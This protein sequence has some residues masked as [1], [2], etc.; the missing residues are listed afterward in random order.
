MH[1]YRL[2]RYPAFH[3]SFPL[4]VCVLYSSFLCIKIIFSPFPSYRLSLSLC[5]NRSSLCQA[6]V[7]IAAKQDASSSL[8]NTLASSLLS[9]FSP[10]DVTSVTGRAVCSK[11]LQIVSSLSSRGYLAGSAQLLA[12]LVSVFTVQGTSATYGTYTG[13]VNNVSRAASS[14]VQ[15][16]QLGMASGEVPVSLV[17]PNIQLSVTSTLIFAS[18]NIV[19]TTPATGSQLAHRS[20]QP[21]VTLGPKGLRDCGATNEYA[22]LSVLQWSINPYEIGRAH[23]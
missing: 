21:K 23:V 3:P 14:L 1:I 20:I 15:G 17:T 7:D 10:L 9:S 2:S 18:S 5:C 13:A 8:L 19:L 22:H 11:A 12:D 6:I 16:V 4:T